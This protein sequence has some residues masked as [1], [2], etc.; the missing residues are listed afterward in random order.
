M[1]AAAAGF[2]LSR[3]EVTGGDAEIDSGMRLG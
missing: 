1:I 2:H 3:G